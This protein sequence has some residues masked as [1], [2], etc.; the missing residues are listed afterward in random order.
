MSARSWI[1]LGAVLAGLSVG[2]GAFG[3]HVLDDYFAEKYREAGE[4]SVAGF[5]VPVSWERLQDFKTGVQYQMYHALGMIAAGLLLQT[6]RRRALQ[7]AAWCFLLGICL[8]SGGLYLYTLTGQRIWGM[9]PPPIGGTSF[10][11][12]WIAMAIGACPCGEPASHD[13]SS[14]GR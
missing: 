4:K 1:T 13:A 14:L 7:A 6:R 11:V 12:G 2:A 5:S 3:A 9:I 10:I 8:F